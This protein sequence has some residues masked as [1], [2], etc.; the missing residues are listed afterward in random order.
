MTTKGFLKKH[1]ETLLVGAEDADRKYR[2]PVAEIEHDETW[3]H[4]VTDRY[5][6]HVMLNIETLPYLRRALAKISRARAAL[7]SAQSG[8]GTR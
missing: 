1:G 2:G 6:G 4:I 8:G 3:L 7:A 5:E